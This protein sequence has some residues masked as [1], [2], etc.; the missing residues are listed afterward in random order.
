MCKNIFRKI[1]EFPIRGKSL[2]HNL[3]KHIVEDKSEMLVALVITG[4]L[5]TRTNNQENI[6]THS[7]E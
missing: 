5:S 2:D 4:K 3:Y 7:E 6:Q 1:N